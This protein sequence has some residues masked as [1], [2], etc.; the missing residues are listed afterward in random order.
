M[1]TGKSAGVSIFTPA[2][3]PGKISQFRHDTD[4][5]ILS[6][7]VLVGSHKINIVN[8]Y[9]PN[10]LSERRAFFDQLQ[11]LFF[12]QG[13]LIIAGDFNCVEHELGKLGSVSSADKDILSTLKSDFSLV[14]V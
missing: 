5:R 12:S 10:A 9:A 1:G 4:C 8:I 14:D 13:D 6:A 11:N 7:L 2:N 3:I